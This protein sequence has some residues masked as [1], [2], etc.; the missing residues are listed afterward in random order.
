MSKALDGIRVIDMT[1]DQA[2]PSCT[3][4]LAWLGAEVI[5]IEMADGRGDRSRWLRRDDPD[6]DSYFYLLLNNNKKSTTLNLRDERGK[7][8]F[9]TLIGEADVMVENRGPGAMD[10]L[11]LGYEDLKQINPRL[12]YASVKGFGGYGPYSDYKCF[13]QV[14]QATSGA[15][16]CTGF[17][18]RPPAM[19]GAGVGDSGTGMHMAIGILAAIVQRAT[20][21]TGQMVE[22]AMQEAVLNL[23]RV[24]FTGTL[25]DGT[26]EP[27]QNSHESRRPDSVGGLFACAPGGPNDYVYLTMPPDNPGMFKAGMQAIGREDLLDDPRFADPDDRAANIED[28]SAIVANWASSRDKHTVMKAFAS[29]GVPCGAVLNTAEVLDNAHLRERNTVADVQHPTRGQYP[30]IGCPV[31]LSDSPVELERPPLYGEHTDHV[32]TNL[33]GLSQTDLDELRRDKVVL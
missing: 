9:K 30:M 22:V 21:G 26:P 3:Q 28:L 27:R 29:K 14:A 10:R 17:D 13:E 2:G 31:R 32:F 1:H 12:I 15:L 6:L 23:T 16:S 18:D 7:D 8:L 19:H 33:G 4:M 20:T 25:T 24:R 11:G 5:K